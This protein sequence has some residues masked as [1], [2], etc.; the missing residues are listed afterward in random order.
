[1]ILVGI[2]NKYFL[3]KPNGEIVQEVPIEGST[4]NEPGLQIKDVS[5]NLEYFLF[6]DRNQI[7]SLEKKE[8]FYSFVAFN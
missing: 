4:P 6:Q 7:Y 2:K 8:E 3:F 1:L 5:D